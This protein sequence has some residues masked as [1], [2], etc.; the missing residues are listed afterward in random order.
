M[1]RCLFVTGK[2]AA[3]SLQAT[4][5]AMPSRL[6]YELAVLP[7]SVA[8]LMD[9]R[10]VI[11]HLANARGCQTVMV[12]GLCNGDLKVLADKLG[13]EAVRGPK[14]LKDLPAFLGVSR[15]LNEYG[16]YQA[17]ILAEIVDAYKLSTEEI[18]AQASYFS[19]NGADII[20]LGCPVEGGFPDI[21]KVIHMLKAAGFRVSIDSFNE[22][23]ILEADRA[24]ADMVLSLNSRNIELARRIHCKVVVIPDFQ[25]GPES[26]ER[27]MARLEAWNIPYV[28][29]PVLSPI[30]FGFAESIENFITLRRNH[31]Q[32]EMLMG[33]GNLTELTDADSTGI[34]AVMAGIVAELE[35]DYVLT[36]EV[37]S[38][39]RGAVR[40]LDLARRLMHYACENKVLPK[41]L[42]DGL[43]TVKDPPFQSFSE[44][45]LRT[46]QSKVRDRNFRIFTDPNY[47]YVFNDRVF[48]K[49]A[50]AQAIFER[51]DVQ[52]ALEAFYL[53][54]ELHKA[55]LALKLGKK[56]IQEEE[57]RWGYLAP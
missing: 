21:E 3:P 33:L 26:L 4:L 24:G 29:D 8:A 37:V 52:S 53:G 10:F 9:I 47:I 43:I 40:E 54:K 31:P 13:V 19:S 57:L 7:I 55:Q 48:V 42:D 14:N 45:E 27:N 34:T 22:K 46:M 51:L 15:N 35:I 28:I 38:W 17:H 36:T 41:N 44:D 2:L 39:A 50:E 49:D 30:G 12:P 18:L 5:Q 20:D 25:Q 11:R 32:A 6:E 16:G 23:D 56:Y 1:P